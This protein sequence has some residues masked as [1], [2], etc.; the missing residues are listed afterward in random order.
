MV[1]TLVA[2]SDIAAFPGAPFADALVDAAAGSVRDAAGWHIAPPVTETMRVVSGGGTVLLLRSLNVATV[3]AVRDVSGDTPDVLT[4]WVA[5]ES[6][7]LERAVGWPVRHTIEVDLTHGYAAC[8]PALLSVIADR[9]QRMAVDATVSS[10]SRG[11]FS[12]T[13]RGRFDTTAAD[14]ILARYTVPPSP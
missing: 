4:G 8:P 5:R 11:P 10:M 14:A 9:C 12:V 6:G 1:N 7:I 2:P 3:T 13:L